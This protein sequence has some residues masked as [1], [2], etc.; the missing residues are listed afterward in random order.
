[1]RDLFSVGSARRASGLANALSGLPSQPSPINVIGSSDW[2]SQLPR[3]APE[4]FQQARSDCCRFVQSRAIYRALKPLKISES[5]ARPRPNRTATKRGSAACK[6][7]GVRGP[8]PLLRLVVL[9]T[10]FGISG[11]L[12]PPFLKPLQLRARRAQ[13]RDGGHGHRNGP[14]GVVR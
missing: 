12:A 6:G 3:R 5:S 7:E 13:L 2:R 4:G 8:F 10:F 14:E 11:A 1:M 9:R